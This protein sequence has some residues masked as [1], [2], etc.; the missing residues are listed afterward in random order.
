MW[1]IIF[2]QEDVDT[3]EG[4]FY[5]GLL[6]AYLTYI[7]LTCIVHFK[8]ITWNLNN[9]SPFLLACLWISY[10]STAYVQST[11]ILSLFEKH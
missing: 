3:L 4:T 5:R 8:K 11:A 10:M 2:N 1:N 6:N 7:F 9:L